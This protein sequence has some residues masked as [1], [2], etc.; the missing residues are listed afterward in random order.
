MREFDEIYDRPE[1]L[2]NFGLYSALRRIKPEQ[3]EE[4]APVESH[5]IIRAIMGMGPG[6]REDLAPTLDALMVALQW[7]H[8]M[9]EAYL[10]EKEKTERA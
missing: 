2:M 4:M 3:F 6:Y 5:T 9:I 1:S 8:E 10:D 7:K